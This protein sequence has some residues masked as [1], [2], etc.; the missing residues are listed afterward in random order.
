MRFAA[1]V[2]SSF[3]LASAASAAPS[4][5]WK[6]AGWYVVMYDP[7]GWREGVLGSFSELSACRAEAGAL[8]G[9][10]PQGEELDAGCVY[11]PSAP[12]PDDLSSVSGVNAGYIKLPPDARVD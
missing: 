6:G 11:L 10:I 4:D 2:L 12:L 8:R 1:L 5:G 3:I 9:E 7:G